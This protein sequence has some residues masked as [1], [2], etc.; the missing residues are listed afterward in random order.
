MAS[1]GKQSEE[2]TFRAYSNQDAATYAKARLRYSDELYQTIIAHHTSSG[3]KLDTV[4]DIGCGPGIATFQ[5]AEY[6]DK[7]IGIDP[8]EGMINTAR[9]QLE[10]SEEKGRDNVRFE[11]S[12]AEDIDPSLIPDGSVDVITAATCAHVRVI[13][14]KSPFGIKNHPQERK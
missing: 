5:L 6:F 3:G 2:S 11:I 9:S 4:V 7:V 12:T 1:M 10:A 14:T 13:L 8:S